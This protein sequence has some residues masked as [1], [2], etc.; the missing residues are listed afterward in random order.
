MVS[1]LRRAVVLALAGVLL[2]AAVAVA[3]NGATVTHFA[4]SYPALGDPALP[5]I[6]CTGNRIVK[7]GPDG[8]VKDTETCVTTYPDY[9][10]V[11][12]PYR[13]VPFT[14]TSLADGNWEDDVWFSDYEALTVLPPFDPPCVQP[15]SDEFGLCSRPAISGQMLVT[16][17]TSTGLYTISVVAYYAP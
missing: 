7:P 9:W 14:G 8:W 15:L 10:P 11:G 17:S 2:S 3:G 1:L 12:V 13:I 16:Y 4:V 5:M 6:D